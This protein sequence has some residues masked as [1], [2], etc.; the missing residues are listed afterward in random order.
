MRTTVL[1]LLLI[2]G[3]QVKADGHLYPSDILLNGKVLYS[4]V[5]GL[6]VNIHTNAIVL[7]EGNIYK[8]RR[9]YGELICDTIKETAIKNA[10]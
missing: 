1:T 8:C 9:R 4:E 3:S 7:Y 6:D 2:F 10:E 5:V